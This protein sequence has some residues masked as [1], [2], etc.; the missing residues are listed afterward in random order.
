M[1]ALITNSPTFDSRWFPYDDIH[2]SLVV[3]AENSNLLWQM[4]DTARCFPGLG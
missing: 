4:A 2:E 1:A 3:L